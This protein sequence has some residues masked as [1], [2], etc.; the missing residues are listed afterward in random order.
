MAGVLAVI[1][2][3][4]FGP[5]TAMAKKDT[6]PSLCPSS[7]FSQPFLSAGDDDW[8][9]LVGGQT[10]DNFD[11]SGWT[12]TDG[13]SV[14]PNDGGGNA[15]TVLDLPGGSTAVS[16]PTCVTADYP[17]ARTMVRDLE[18][19]KGIKVSVEYAD[20]GSDSWTEPKNAGRVDPEGTDWTVSDPLRLKPDKGPGLQTMRL[21][22]DA[23]GKSSRFQIYNLYIDPRMK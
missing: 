12:L 18:G 14:V 8:Y 22:F 16:P 19:S 20:A 21:T 10:A 2:A 23:R 5:A 3:A 17:R 15:G 6:A 1:A 4:T 11:G 13:A 9:T 7:S